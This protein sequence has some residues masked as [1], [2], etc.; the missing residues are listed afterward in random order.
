[1]NKEIATGTHDFKKIIETNSLYVDKTLF[2][3]DLIDDTSDVVCFPRPRRFGKTLNMSMLNYYFNINYKDNTLFKGLKIMEQDEKYLSEM[4][5]YPVV[6]LSLKDAK[7]DNYKGFIDNYKEIMKSL[8]SKYNYLLKSDKLDETDKEDFLKIIRKQENVLLPNALAKLV[9]YLYKH[10][11]LQVIV[12]L[13]EYDAPILNAYLEG[14][15]DKMITFM[16]QLFVTT[17]K[18]NNNLRKGVMLI[19]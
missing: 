18:D 8:Y 13:D 1:M 12:L 4:N 19:I 17:F 14:F 15:Y 10:Y 7:F 3:K 9:E 11:E 2:I 5:K 16:K 6:S